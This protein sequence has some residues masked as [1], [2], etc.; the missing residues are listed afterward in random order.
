[1]ICFFVK[2]GAE[3][4]HGGTGRPQHQQEPGGFGHGGQHWRLQRARRQHRGRHLHR[5]RPS[6]CTIGCFHLS[7]LGLIKKTVMKSFFEFYP[8]KCQ[9]DPK[10]PPKTQGAKLWGEGV[11]GEN[12]D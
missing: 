9:E 10:P 3:E 12:T 2:R 8:A 1:M 4:Q 11:G 5:L 6:E 7:T